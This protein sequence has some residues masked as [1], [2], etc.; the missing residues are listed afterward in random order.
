MNKQDYINYKMQKEAFFDF[1]QVAQGIGSLGRGL[2]EG[3]KTVGKGLWNAGKA[4]SNAIGDWASN[5]YKQGLDYANERMRARNPEGAMGRTGAVVQHMGDQIGGM[6][7]SVVSNTAG[8]L[9]QP[10]RYAKALGRNLWNGQ[11]WSKSNEN[12]ANYARAMYAPY[13]GTASA[14]AM[15]K[16]NYNPTMGAGWVGNR[17]N[18]VNSLRNASQNYDKSY[19]APTQNAQLTQHGLDRRGL[20][21]K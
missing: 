12:A 2:W 4:T 15:N 3:A 21:V 17:D 6:A 18:Y 13:N 7:N 14:A 19:L 16:A 8:R 1:G 20:P 5:T 10:Y 11:G 9:K